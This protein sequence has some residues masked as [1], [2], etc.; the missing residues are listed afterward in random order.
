MEPM[1]LAAQTQWE[2]MPP[3]T[4]HAPEATLAGQVEP[5]YEVGGDAF[6]YPLDRGVAHLAIFDAMGHGVQASVT[7]ALAVGSYRHSRRCGHDLVRTLAAADAAVASQF[8]DG[9]FVTAMLGQL[10][11][12][13][14]RLMLLNAGHIQPVL[15]R[16]HHV[17]DL[18]DVPASLPLGLGGML[19][20]AQHRMVDVMLEPGDRLLLV[21]DGILAARD[22]AG[23]AFDAQRLVEVTERAALD[24]MPLA[25]L[26]RRIAAGV[27]AW[28][29]GKLRGDASL[30]IL[31]YTGP[32]HPTVAPPATAPGLLA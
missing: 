18:V 26:A 1:N 31:E 12:A 24:R 4:A 21:T 29:D 19:P 14:G 20:A 2:L 13:T 6:H 28:Q 30:L 25:E 7:T 9:R 16:G 8:G 22:A 3:L 15:L 23:V 5:A 32:D 17:V 11:L 10:E 27:H